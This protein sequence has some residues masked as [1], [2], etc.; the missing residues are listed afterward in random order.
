MEAAD[1]W[2]AYAQALL[3]KYPDIL[4]GLDAEKLQTLWRHEAQHMPETRLFPWL[5]FDE[6]LA[7]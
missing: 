4:P 5:E 3:D 6:L 2:E 7:A 1:A